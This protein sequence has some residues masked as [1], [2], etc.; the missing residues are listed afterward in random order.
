MKNRL[1]WT[2]WLII[3]AGTVALFWVIDALKQRTEQQMSFIAEHHQVELLRYGAEAE[4]VLLEDGEAALSVWLEKLQRDEHTWASVSTSSVAPLAGSYLS[5][6]FLDGFRLGRNVEWKIHLYFKDN[7]I[8]DV[9]F[10]DGQTHFL[11]QL[12]QRMRPGTYFPYAH[13]GIQIALPFVV[14]CLVTWVLYRHVMRPLQQLERATRQF[15]DGQFDVRVKTLL[16]KRNDEI[17]ALAETFDQMAERTGNL[18][19]NQRQLLSDLSHELRTPLTRLD[20]AVDCFEEGVQTDSTIDRLRHESAVM[21]D[22]VDDALM[23]AWLNNENP[24]LTSDDFDLA[25]LLSVICEDARFEYPDR[26]LK[27]LLPE[28]GLIQG[29]SQRALGQAV[30]NIVRNALNHTPPGKSVTVALVLESDGY[31]VTVRDEGVG[32]PEHL[33]ADIFRPFFR[34]DKS[35]TD[36]TQTALP[37]AG[38]K[39][40]G[41]GLGLALARR[42]IAAVGGAVVAF[43]HQVDGSD[44]VAGLQI[45]IVLPTRW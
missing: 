42:Q 35:R 30:E 31:R 17:T 20:M 14:L 27:L 2:L 22:L 15:S 25:E 33:L 40:G 43:N 41:F 21:R 26:H 16:G 23:L 39:H 18:V 3:A 29:S 38:K 28:Q 6:Q 24:R 9:P 44:R 8:M 12:P 32:V 7:P 37:V 36:S 45:D 34:V 1:L 11:I 19:I 10:A 13:L 5:T 4:R